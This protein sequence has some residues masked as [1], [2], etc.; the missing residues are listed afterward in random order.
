MADDLGSRGLFTIILEAGWMI[1]LN[2]LSLLGNLFVCL[3][4]YKN[5]SLR[6]STSVYIIALAV[7]DL[8][9]AFFVMPF[10]TGVLLL[11]KWP[12]GDTV[13]QIHAFFSLFVVYVSPVTMG[14]TAFNRYVRM[15]KSDQRYRQLFSSKKSRILLS[16]TWVLVASYILVLRFADIQRFQFLPGYA[17]CLNVQSTEVGKY[18]HYVVVVGIFLI[19]PLTV[20]IF[21]Y[22][23]VFK[24][25]R[26][27][28]SVVAQTL[29][30]RGA[31]DSTISSNEIRICR[32]LVI[33]VFAFMLCWIPAWVITILTRFRI[34]MRMPR[35]M[36]LLCTF[37]LNVSN[38]INPFIYA[39]MNS[40]FRKEFRKLLCCGS[41][42][43]VQQNPAA[44]N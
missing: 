23:K 37:C 19:A 21:S 25:I 13:C 42:G 36:E 44:S 5:T 2:I 16:S 10:A 27:H 31:R 41:G 9:S 4:V 11:G 8:L 24:K 12:F 1:V 3:S 30:S 39:G 34:V 22:K 14:L 26:E 38:T 7:S 17:A 20:T 15:C 28:N 32:S 18:I 43:L 6:T 40:L 29:R 35:E 33:V